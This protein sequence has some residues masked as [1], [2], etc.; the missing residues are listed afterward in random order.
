M[1][2]VYCTSCIKQWLQIQQL[3]PHCK[4]PWP[5]DKITPNL[6]VQEFID[7]LPAK[8]TVP[9]CNFSGTLADVILHVKNCPFEKISCSNSKRGCKVV[10]ARKE[11]Q[12]HEQV[13]EF[14]NVKCA[15]GKVLLAKL[16]EHHVNEDCPK[17]QLDCLLHC[18]QKVLRENMEHH[19][20]AKCVNRAINCPNQAL[21]CNWKG[22]KKSCSSC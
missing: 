17:V 3:C 19:I 9:N 4:A 12:P 21:G 7:S 15:C 18:G 10:G 22:M 14:R 6:L 5:K 1:R 16:I 13:C 2:T 8:C 20:N 11:V